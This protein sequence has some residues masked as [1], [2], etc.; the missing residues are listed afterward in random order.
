MKTVELLHARYGFTALPVVDAD[1]R[2]F[3]VVTDSG[4]RRR[5]VPAGAGSPGAAR[6]IVVRIRTIDVPEERG[7]TVEVHSP[8][9]PPPCLVRWPADDRLRCS[10]LAGDATVVAPGELVAAEE[11]DRA[12]LAALREVLT[13]PKPATKGPS[14]RGTPG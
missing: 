1:D 2:L 11:R 10:S 13:G 12:R 4:F 3:G 5:R 7:R 6:W 8:E 9:G 14:R